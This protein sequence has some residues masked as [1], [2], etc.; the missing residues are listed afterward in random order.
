MKVLSGKGG[1]THFKEYMLINSH[2]L[3]T[4]R[5]ISHRG[6]VVRFSFK[7]LTKPV[8]KGEI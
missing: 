6:A 3:I 8:I 7:C 1:V 2:T 4:W 5:S